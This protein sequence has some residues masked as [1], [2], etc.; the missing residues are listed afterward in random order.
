[1]LADRRAF[2]VCARRSVGYRVLGA[3]SRRARDARNARPASTRASRPL[4]G[5]K[6]RPPV[7]AK[8]PFLAPGCGTKVPGGKSYIQKLRPYVAPNNLLLLPGIIFA[9][10]TGTTGSAPAGNAP[11]A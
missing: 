5:H 6:R 7:V 1:M 8:E 3:E 9:D 4:V 10:M 11:S 2:P